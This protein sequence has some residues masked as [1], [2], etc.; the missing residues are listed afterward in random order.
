MSHAID[1][2]SAA[3]AP[4]S[5]VTLVDLFQG[6]AN[7]NG[8][9]LAF[10]E[11][12]TS[13]G[14]IT[15]RTYAEA[16]ATI[17][18]LVHRLE[19]IGLA[20]G[21]RILVALGGTI[22]APLALLAILKAGYVPCLL[23]VW[24]QPETLLEA[25][26]ASGAKAIVTVGALGRLRPAE[27]MRAAAA[28]PDGPRYVL[29]FGDRLPAGVI[30][31]SDTLIRSVDTGFHI[32]F[33]APDGAPAPILTLDVRP[34]GARWIEHDQEALAA[35]ALGMVTQCGL[36]SAEPILSTL[37]PVSA[38]A[39]CTGLIPALLT[40]AT[41]HLHGVFDAATLLL[42]LGM[43]VK[44]HLVA[45]AGLE[46][47]LQQAGLLGTETLSSTVLLHRPPARLDQRDRL[48][49][50]ES[51]VID[52]VALGEHAMLL[53]ART[54]EG[55]PGLALDAV[56]LPDEPDGALIL[57]ARAGPGERIEVRGAAVSGFEDGGARTGLA[58]I[59]TGHAV[60]A[61][62]GRILQVDP[63]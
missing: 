56:R 38:A 50:R 18:G 39:L 8:Q 11:P 16:A 59:P 55:L 21:S 45:P 32:P 43:M 7:L 54:S 24:L 52:A 29:A 51:P 15:R 34:S 47:S 37:A 10:A 1:I 25:L 53:G 44:P 6:S 58:W 3:T 40:G 20:R 14:R 48:R 26:Q 41:L 31:L 36:G 33:D 49:R 19:E 28:A 27:I 23:P 12:V 62:R 2:E 60:R 61:E 9:A 4:W 17:D 5:G 35:A 13:G 57:E 42:Q 22:E 30:P 46:Q 63:A